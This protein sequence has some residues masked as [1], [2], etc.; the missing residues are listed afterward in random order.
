MKMM[1]QILE[2]NTHPCLV[3]LDKMNSFVGLMA[4]GLG[5]QRWMTIQKKHQRVWW[6]DL[7]GH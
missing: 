1:N 7:E 5:S 4:V 2:R 6:D 3:S